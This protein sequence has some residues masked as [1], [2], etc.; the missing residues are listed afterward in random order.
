MGLSLH[1]PF[2]AENPT[3]RIDHPFEFHDFAPSGSR[4]EGGVGWRR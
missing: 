2:A 3:G 4:Q 1:R